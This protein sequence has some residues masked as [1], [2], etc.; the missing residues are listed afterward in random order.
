MK[1]KFEVSNPINLGKLTSSQL[2]GLF[3]GILLG[4]GCIRKNGDFNFTST[5]KLLV[6][7]VE[8]AILASTGFKTTRQHFP[9]K[10][11]QGYQESDIYTVD[12][13]SQKKYFLKMRP[14]FY[15]EKGRIITGKALSKLHFHALAYWYMSDGS[16]SLMGRSKGK[17]EKR[18][19]ILSTH[20]YTK[21]ENVRIAQWF[22]ENLAIDA[23]VNKQGK[24]YHIAFPV[25]EAQ[26]FFAL[27]FPYVL[28]DFYYKI[29]MAYE[30]RPG[31]KHIIAEYKEIYDEIKAHRSQEVWDM[32]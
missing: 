17:I 28:P 6:D 24:Y 14:H 21:E 31:T 23:R 2:D 16:L 4:D 19:V 11:R 18:R 13:Y 3:T 30:D 25:K 20:A 12:I 15:N 26:K 27:I 1:R 10:F 32:I 7:T 5:N 8:N 9:G 22:R 29:D